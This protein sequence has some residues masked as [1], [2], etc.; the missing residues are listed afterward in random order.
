M[1]QRYL[2][3]LIQGSLRAS[4]VLIQGSLR[5]SRVL[6]QGPLRASTEDY[7]IIVEFDIDDGPLRS[8]R[9]PL[10]YRLITVLTSLVVGKSDS[11]PN[12]DS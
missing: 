1:I 2:R 8:F 7:L 6:I 5:A 10:I 11:A 4:R 12:S 9:F 3:V